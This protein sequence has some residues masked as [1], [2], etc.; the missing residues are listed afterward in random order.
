MRGGGLDDKRKMV[1]FAVCLIYGS[2]T[3]ILVYPKSKV[4]G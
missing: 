2:F 4:V 3:C 1:G